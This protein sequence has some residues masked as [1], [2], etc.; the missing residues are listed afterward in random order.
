MKRLFL[1]DAFALIYRA[2]YAFISNPRRTSKGLDTGAI[3]G[4]MNT[5]LELI[6]KEKPTH[7]GVAFD[8][9]APTFRHESYDEYKANR[10]AQPEAISMAIPYVKRLLEAMRIPVLEQDGYEADDIIGTLARYAASKGFVVYMVTSDKD[11]CQL[12]D[13][14]IFLYKPSTKTK[15]T[16]VMGKEE[17][18]RRFG[19]EQPLQVIDILALQGDSSDNVPGIPGIG[20][21]TAQKL[22]AEYSSIEQLIDQAHRL[23]KR[24]A[25]LISQYAQQALLCKQ[26][27]TIRTDVPLIIDLQAL[28]YEPFDA[29]ALIPLLDE[30]EFRSIKARLLEHNTLKKPAVVEQAQAQQVALN[31]LALFVGAASAN[32]SSPEQEHGHEVMPASQKDNPTPHKNISN[33]WHNYHLIDQDHLLQLL[34]EQLMQLPAFCF[35]TETTA[36]DVLN[37]RLVGIAFA[38]YPHEAYYVPLPD[39]PEATRAILRQFKPVFEKEGSL[40]IAQ[41]LKYDMAILRNYGIG[42]APPYYDTML[43]AYLLNP[44]E[45]HGMSYLARKYLH[46]EPIHIE[47][48]IGKRGR[49]QTS[50]S[51]VA[52]ERVKEYA[53][54]DADI[55]WQLYE[56]LRIALAQMPRLQ[57]LFDEIEIPLVA[58]LE[59]MERTG[60]RID[61]NA[62]AELSQQLAEGIG[63]LEKV[64]YELAGETFNIASPKQLGEILFEK[65]KLDKKPKKTAT[66]QY[67]TSEEVLQKLVDKHPI[68]QHILDIRELQK[69]KSTYVDPLPMLIDQS[70]RL[71]TSFNQAVTATGRLSSTNPN[72]QNIPIRTE[73]G[74]EIRKA[75]IPSQQEGYIVSADYSQIELRLMAHLSQDEGMLQAFAEGRDIHAFTAA[76]IFHV[77]VEEVTAAMRRAAKTANFG[78]LYG[79]S[80]FGLAERLHISRSEA[81]KL[82]DEYF[83][84]F[85]A[86]R[87]YQEQVIQQA[88]AQG[89]VETIFGR[90]RY[91]PG[92]DSRN[93]TVRG[94][95]ERNAINTPLQGSAA[96]IIKRAMITIHSWMQQQQLRSKM[97]LQVHDELL[98]DADADEVDLILEHVPRLMSQAASLSVPLVVEANKGKNWLEAH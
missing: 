35:D 59:D 11:Y 79:V 27:V 42:L 25:V 57:V 16:E 41:N 23:P 50:M 68:V 49:L 69:L 72:L 83:R 21:K 64:I 8:T 63:Q 40:K 18:K 30:L 67:A 97:I 98:F 61:T 19:I 38:W 73:R 48:L 56:K 5:L 51:E 52:V 76:R 3:Y 31:Q 28:R 12:V 78:I 85:P 81:K 71:H 74:Q 84:Q 95:A 58:V 36:L 96:D 53:A 4:F 39:E 93:Q 15:P 90:R 34:I 43:A 70:G 75:F 65:L 33:T 77:A 82:I 46:Y 20:E 66:G 22:I 47:T 89:Y 62:L 80:A 29:E 45:K 94:H 86:V 9:A 44:D 13:D 7:I 37:A 60:V 91:L 6:Q 26:L 55:T 87:A 1:L 92:I 24:L 88:R 32:T 10:D 14:N 54:E 2:Y 17:V